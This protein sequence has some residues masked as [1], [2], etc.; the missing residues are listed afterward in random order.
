MPEDLDWSLLDE[1]MNPK[2]DKVEFN[3]VKHLVRKVAFDVYKAKSGS[4]T[5]WELRQADDGTQYLVALYDDPNDIVVE[6]QEDS[7]WTAVADNE[8]KNVTLSYKSFP[9]KRFAIA[10]Y[11]VEP[12]RAEE[13]ARFVEK[14]T[15]SPVFVYGLLCAMNEHKKAAVMG[16]LGEKDK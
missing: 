4:D 12:E 15:K 14:K 9:I 5:L 11:G 8:G 6:S 1:R 3:S 13:F 2:K 16:L 7:E 10:E